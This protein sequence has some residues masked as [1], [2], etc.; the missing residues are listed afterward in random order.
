MNKEWRAYSREITTYNTYQET[1]LYTN[2]QRVMD[3]YIY[4]LFKGDNNSQQKTNI[5][6][7]YSRTELVLKFSIKFLNPIYV[8]IFKF[9]LETKKDQFNC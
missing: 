3:N 1:R 6:H 5:T 2:E 9:F 7:M 8:S 4:S